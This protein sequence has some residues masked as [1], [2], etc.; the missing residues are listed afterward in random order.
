M[1]R[2]W[3]KLARYALPQSRSWAV[4]LVLMCIGASLGLLAPWP[5]KLIVDYVLPGKPFP[6]AVAWLETLP[7]MSSGSGRLG[8]LAAATVLLFLL[9]R[10]TGI[11]QEYVQTGASTRM[12]YHLAGD[13]FLELQRRSLLFHSRQRTGDLVRRVTADTTC[14]RELMTHVCLP[15][16]KST[17]IMA[18]MFVVMWQISPALALF[19]IG[20]A[21]PLGV[22]VRIFARPMSE[23][24]FQQ[25]ERQGEVAAFAEQTLTALP[26]VQAFGRE[27]VED[28]RF[29]LLAGRTVQATLRA[30][31]AQHQFKVSTGAVNAAATAVVMVVGGLAVLQAQLSVGDLLVLLSY[32]AAL[33]SPIETLAYL[34]EGFASAGA[35]AR[36]VF[37]VLE[38][39]E[40]P[41]AD[42]P[43]ALPVPQTAAG[44]RVRLENVTFG[45]DPERPILCDV[46]LE[47]RPGEIVALAGPTGAGKSTLAGLIL[48]FFDPQRGAVY[49]N[50]LDAREVQ[51]ASL[52][53]QIALVPQ[54]PYLLPMTIAENIA[55]GRP[56]ASRDEIVAAAMEASADRFI[57]RLPQGYETMVGD[58]GAR[59]S[60]GEK[61]RLSIA[62]ALLKNAPVFVL[63]EPTSALDNETEAELLATLRPILA[64]RTALIIAHRWST[65]RLADRILVVQQ[66]RIVEDGAH[67]QLLGSGGA[68]AD[69]FASQ[70]RGPGDRLSSGSAKAS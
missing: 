34:S 49:F 68:Y 63:D 32:F 43:D 48:R 21:V 22:L 36:R 41:I 33:Y 40:P 67:E 50:D 15:L 5:L 23:R 51:L 60:A 19:A 54:E 38:S 27:E 1:N 39:G 17:V 6:A 13:L 52:R 4:I 69:L 37:G 56:T 46:S 70:L 7:G 25:W 16:L 66:G 59:L 28:R 62:R 3:L 53:S 11:V 44:V 14:V 26:I 65:V 29:S 24:Q 30:E 18:S 2:W 35:G 47:L 12:M 55:F 64:R 42:R 57:S 20:L 10:V 45:Y 9:R 61:Q 58:R 8:W 31:V